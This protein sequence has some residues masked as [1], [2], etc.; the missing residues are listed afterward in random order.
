MKGST[1]D[2]GRMRFRVGRAS[3]RSWLL[4]LVSVALSALGAPGAHAST[5]TA[6][7]AKADTPDVAVVIAGDTGRTTTLRSGEEDFVRLWRLLSPRYRE[8]E[9][10]PEAW[11]AGRFPKVRATVIWGLTGVGGWP[12][13]QRAPGGDVAI[14][15]QDQVFVAADGTPWVRS[16][17]SPDVED[18]DI[19]WHRA[20]R[21][22]FE[23]LAEQGRLFG[24]GSTSVA[25]SDP[26]AVER[27]RW[28]IPGLAA[29]LVIGVGG[30][31]VIRRA[32]AR[33]EAAGP[34]REPRQELIDL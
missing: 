11:V 16:D 22:V 3:A 14:E 1:D 26:H 33:Q 18:D 9:P 7:C 2:G 20:P 4:S 8:T 25:D 13:T 34:P 31:L 6:F 19:R 15:R 24:S 27:A 32:A 29:G 17:P 12:Q 10:V 23:Q 5:G 28:A 21:S 30:T